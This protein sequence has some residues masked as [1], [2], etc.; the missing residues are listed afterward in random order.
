MEEKTNI[1]GNVIETIANRAAKSIQ[2]EDGDYIKDGL[3]YCGKCNTPKQCEI[4]FNGSVI[5]PMCL[6]KCAVEKRNQEKAE[7]DH[8]QFLQRVADLR[9]KGFPQHE[10]QS[11]NFDADDGANEKLTKVAHNYVENFSEFRNKGKGLLLFGS[12]GTGK[13]FYAACIANGLIDKGKSCLMTNFARLVNTI[14]GMYEGKQEYLDELSR[15]S[16]LIIDDLAA[17]RDT[18]YMNEIVFNIIDSR[19]RAGLPIIVTTNLTAD[20][21]KNPAD[22]RKQR[23][24]SRLLEMCIP[25][26]VKGEDRR[27][28]KLKDDFA[29]FNEL[30]GI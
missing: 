16:L 1:Y 4:E 11:W 23:T 12:V 21:I 13:T 2:L 17:E 27:R 6:C 24:Y 25:I 10:L 28:K 8:R 18:E 15:Y 9:V 5:K 7:F 29:E 22:I 14:S 20:E 19:Y 3:I 26:E 30:L